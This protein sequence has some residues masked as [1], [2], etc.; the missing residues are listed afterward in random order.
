[1]LYSESWRINVKWY[2]TFICVAL[3]ISSTSKL[4][5]AALKTIPKKISTTARPKPVFGQFCSC[6]VT[7]QYRDDN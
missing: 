6:V 3:N 1:M 2:R 7:F 5:I 4:S